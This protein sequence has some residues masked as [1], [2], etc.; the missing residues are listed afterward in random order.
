MPV[1]VASLFAGKALRTGQTGSLSALRVATA[2]SKNEKWCGELQRQLSV[3]LV[4][5][6][7]EEF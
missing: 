5:Q 3:L 6:F 4:K 7:L 2:S 1:C